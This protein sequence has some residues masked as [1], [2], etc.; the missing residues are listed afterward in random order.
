MPVYPER[1]AME[2][3]LIELLRSVG[4][5]NH[6]SRKDQASLMEGDAAPQANKTLVHYGQSS[7]DHQQ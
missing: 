7:K 2:E 6:R 1:D 5:R 3:E 4:R